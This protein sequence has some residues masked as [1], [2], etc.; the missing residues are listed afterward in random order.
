MRR[1]VKGRAEMIAA[2]LL[3]CLAH[4]AALTAGVALVSPPGGTGGAESVAF[5]IGS[6]RG[7]DSPLPSS[8]AALPAAPPEKPPRRAE[9]PEERRAAEASAEAPS[10]PRD[11]RP[12]VITVSEDPRPARPE[13][14]AREAAR[15]ARGEDGRAAQNA[16][17][18][19]EYLSLV[20]RRI[21]ELKSFPAEALNEG[22]RGTA[23]VGFRLGRDGTVSG[24]R[25]VQSSHSPL[26]D[27]QARA[28]VDRAAPFPPI[29]D[30]FSGDAL[31]LRVPISFEIAR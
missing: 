27:A 13:R 19:D 31:E 5:T 9:E 17:G 6:V 8:A 7:M 24:V 28:T 22:S 2:L 15:P 3:S 14:E 12:D 23:V 25:I 21:S 11:S 1:W 29:P 4:A 26:L 10:L 30:R 20:R 16:G 18:A